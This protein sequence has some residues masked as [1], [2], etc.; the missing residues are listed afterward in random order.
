MPE[1]MVMKGEEE[2]EE[3][4][5]KGVLMLVR[6]RGVLILSALKPQVAALLSAMLPLASAVSEPASESVGGG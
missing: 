6:K 3:E 5:A 2:E 4:E 1:G